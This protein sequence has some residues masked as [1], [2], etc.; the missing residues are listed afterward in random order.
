MTR[1]TTDARAALKVG[2]AAVAVIRDFVL[3]HSDC[4]MHTY[5]KLL[6]VAAVSG[7]LTACSGQSI[8]G[9][10]KHAQ[11]PSRLLRLS[12]DGS[13][14]AN[15]GDV[16]T[17]NVDGKRIVLSDPMFGNATGLI[18]GNTIIIHARPGSDTANNLAGTWTKFAAGS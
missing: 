14:M 4:H 5:Q 10:Y 8:E 16:G 15:S 18:D 9:A 11:D 2:A 6:F 17:Y 1:R 12:D 7:L 13:F 3:K